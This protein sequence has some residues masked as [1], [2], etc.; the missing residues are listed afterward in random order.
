MLWHLGNLQTLEG[1][2][3]QCYSISRDKKQLN[4]TPSNSFRYTNQLTWS[5]HS[6]S[7]TSL[8]SYTQGHYSPALITQGQSQTT[9]ESL[10][11]PTLSL[12][13]PM[14]MIIKAL[15]HSPLPPSA[16]WLTLVCPYVTLHV[17]AWPHCTKLS[18]QWQSSLDPLALWHLKFSINTSIL[19]HCPMSTSSR[20]TQNPWWEFRPHTHFLFPHFPTLKVFYLSVGFLGSFL[21]IT[22]QRKGAPR[23]RPKA[24]LLTC[25]HQLQVFT[26]LWPLMGAHDLVGTKVHSSIL[27]LQICE[28]E[29]SIVSCWTLLLLVPRV[30]QLPQHK[31]HILEGTLA[32]QGHVTTAF[33]HWYSRGIEEG[34]GKLLWKEFRVSWTLHLDYYKHA[35]RILGIKGEKSWNLGCKNNQS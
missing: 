25:D 17:M 9:R 14:E 29:F 3:S 22:G 31:C 32:L 28:E 30:L 35:P 27:R 13:L 12:L 16:F 4:N 34:F 26:L 6:Q 7:P 21:P 18:P 2:P 10:Y 1:C 11:T 19:R 20:P 23:S 5:P 24:V 15:S 33:N 8:G